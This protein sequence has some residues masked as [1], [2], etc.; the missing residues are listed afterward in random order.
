MTMIPWKTFKGRRKLDL[1]SLVVTEK[2][3]TYEAVVAYFHGLHVTPPGLEEYNSVSQKSKPVDSTAKNP[4]SKS[5]V[6]KPRASSGAKVP[7]K[8]LE[9]PGEMWQDGLEG[10]YQTKKPATKKS[11]PTRK[12][13]SKTRKKS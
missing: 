7:A 6:K 4:A 1:A 5:T 10:S 9:N 11:T 2:L 12:S 3:A 8:G 13:T